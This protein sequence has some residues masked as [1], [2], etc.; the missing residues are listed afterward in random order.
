MY[1]RQGRQTLGIYLYQ[2]VIIEIVM[3]RWVKIDSAS[4]AIF[5]FIIAPAVS[6]GVLLLCLWLI[7][8][9]R[10]SRVA[11]TLLLGLPWKRA[12]K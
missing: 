11:S 2:T 9:T 10:R 6:L 8:L 4:P 5:D 3:S 7:N 12:G 1:K